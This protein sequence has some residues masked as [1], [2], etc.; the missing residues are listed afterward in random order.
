MYNI[1]YNNIFFATAKTAKLL[2]PLLSTDIPADEVPDDIRMTNYDVI[3]ASLLSGRGSVYVLPECS[4]YPCSVHIKLPRKH[5]LKT[6]LKVHW[7]V[8]SPE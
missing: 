5:R 7:E 1:L 8:Y 6:Q 2:N 4:F 3:A